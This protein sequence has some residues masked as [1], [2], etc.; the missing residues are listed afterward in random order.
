MKFKTL[1]GREV[2]INVSKYLIDWN[3]PQ[4]K[5]KSKFQYRVTQFFK[6]YWQHSICLC[7]LKLPSARLFVDL[8]N[9]SAKIA[10]EI[11]GDQH[12]K[13]SFF[14]KNRLD[15]LATF[16]GYEGKISTDFSLWE[17]CM[18]GDTE[19]LHYMELYNKQDVVTLEK[20]F[21]KLRPYAKGLPNLDL[22]VDQ[23]TSVCP[24]CGGNNIELYKTTV[25]SAGTI[26]RVMKC[27]D[28]K[29]LFKISNSQYL[30][31]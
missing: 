31:L 15:F 4:E 26:Q 28:D 9:A 10:V 30:K 5:Y 6:P 7:E 2:N 8:I 13:L 22:Y 14:H 1:Q 27:K 18:A 16:L 29:H 12:R 17:E 3:A 23:K 21:L 20:V 25:T 19:A 11:S 24:I